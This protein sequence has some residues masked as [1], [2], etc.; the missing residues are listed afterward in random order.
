MRLHALPLVLVL[1]ACGGSPGPVHDATS[2]RLLAAADSAAQRNGGEA[3][4]VEAV[5]T[6]RGKAADLTG[7]SNQNQGEDVW[8]VQVSGDHYRCDVCSHPAGA[9]A[10]RGDFITIVLRASDFEGTDGGLGPKTDLSAFGEVRVL[11][12]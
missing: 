9:Q 6:T 11:R 7:H 10:P 1:A 5:E 2:A 12:G 8:V 3:K 4:H